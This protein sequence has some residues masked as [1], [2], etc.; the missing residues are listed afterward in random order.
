MLAKKSELFQYT[1][2]DYKMWDDDVRVE[3]IDGVV[4]DLAA[5][6]QNHQKVSIA[7]TLIFGA[8]LR[9]KTCDFFVAPSDV[10]LNYKDEDNTVV[11]PDLFVVC[12]KTKL[13]G[14]NCN[15]APDLVI[16][17]LSPSNT[18]MDTLLKFNAYLKAG[19]K[20][21]WIV[22]PMDETVTVF[23]LNNGAYN[24]FAYGRGDDDDYK[25]DTLIKVSLFD[26]FVVNTD[27]IFESITEKK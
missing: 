2:A 26:D 16:E 24:A 18:K 17:I 20:E 10:R 21:Y 4:Y 23:L 6:S 12:D 8:Y 22:N 14:Q 27:D 11:Q 3:L 13:D 5:P 19:V 1:Y 9:N 25:T 15:G 7:L